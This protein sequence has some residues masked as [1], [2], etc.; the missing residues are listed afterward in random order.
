MCLVVSLC[1]HCCFIGEY[2]PNVIVENILSTVSQ[3]S[4]CT[5]NVIAGFQHPSPPVTVTSALTGIEG[6]E[7]LRA[8]KSPTVPAKDLDPV[9]Y[10]VDAHRTIARKNLDR[11]PNMPG[12]IDKPYPTHYEVGG[13]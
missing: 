10:R 5:R 6:G 7:R 13:R 1:A 9:L 3:G 4:K 2:I 12:W 8:S 11:Y